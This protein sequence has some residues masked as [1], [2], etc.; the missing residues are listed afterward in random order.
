MRYPETVTL[1]GTREDDERSSQLHAPAPENT[2][3]RNTKQNKIAASPPLTAGKKLFE[4]SHPHSPC[5]SRDRRQLSR[6]R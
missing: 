6:Y 4:G 2:K 1:F 3:N 5:H